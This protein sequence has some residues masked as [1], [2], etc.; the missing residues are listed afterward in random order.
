MRG[1]QLVTIVLALSLSVGVVMVMIHAD[2]V[3]EPT[4]YEICMEYLGEERGGLYLNPI[5]RD[6]SLSE[7]C[8]WYTANGYLFD[9]DRCMEEVGAWGYLNGCI[10]N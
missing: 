5:G 2:T 10:V 3:R 4:R 1:K 8:H 6:A 7:V 9:E